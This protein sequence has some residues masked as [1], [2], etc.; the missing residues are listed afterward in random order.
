MAIERTP[1]SSSTIKAIGHD[2]EDT[3][4]IEFHNGGCYSYSPVSKD[5]HEALLSAKSIGK[6]FH[7]N[8]RKNYKHTKL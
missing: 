1:V 4:E 2:G 5:V 8:I 6:H 7:E 3:L